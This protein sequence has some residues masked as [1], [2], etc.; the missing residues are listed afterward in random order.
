MK[1]SCWKLCNLVFIELCLHNEFQDRI[2]KVVA[3]I[4]SLHSDTYRPFLIISTAASLHS[5]EDEFYQTDPSI[6]VVIYNGN[7]EI[8][9]N[10]R[11]LEFYDKEQCI[12][13]QVLIV[14]PDVIVEVYSRSCLIY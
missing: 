12:L 13:F 9:N 4:L 3:F 6:D 8:R 7:K 11:R 5:W 10:I 2:L 1:F 14:A